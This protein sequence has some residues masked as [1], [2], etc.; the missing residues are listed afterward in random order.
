MDKSHAGKHILVVNDEP[1]ILNLFKD[2][3]SEEGYRVSL[4]KFDRDIDALQDV[5]RQLR[6]DLVILDFIIG[7]EHKGWQL[8]QVLKMDRATRDI[9][10][11]ICTAA[12]H[13]VTE[14]SS[15]L[16]EL[17]VHVVLKPFDIDHLLE[18]VTKVWQA[19]AS[20]A[21]GLDTLETEERG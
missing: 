17:G 5:V 18:I 9:S 7:G 10:V 4:D 1:A 6:P 15:H 2:L 11:V 14:L 8:L 20:H 3:L 21:P 19:E 12:A 13:Q 16:N